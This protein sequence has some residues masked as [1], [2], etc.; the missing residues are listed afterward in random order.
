MHANSKVVVEDVWRI[1]KAFGVKYKEDKMNMFNLLLRVGG[2]GKKREA[3]G[4]GDPVHSE[5][6]VRVDGNESLAA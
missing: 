6:P 4:G 5:V 1:R 2:R 3:G